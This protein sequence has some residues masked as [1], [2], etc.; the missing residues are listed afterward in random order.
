MVDL[1]TG[2]PLFV[3][4]GVRKEGAGEANFGLLAFLDVALG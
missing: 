1:Q 3:V 4:R 2:S